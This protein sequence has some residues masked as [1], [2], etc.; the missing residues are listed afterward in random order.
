MLLL[1]Y[2][3]I[4][5]MID[6]KVP[7]NQLEAVVA[8]VLKMVGVE[9]RSLPSRGTAQNMR[10]EMGHVADVVAGALLAKS[11]NVSGASDDTTKRQRSLAAD[12][13]HFKLPDGSFRTL[14]IGLSCKMSS[15]TAAAKVQRFMEKL[16]QV[17]AAVRLSVPLHHGDEA[18]WDRITLLDLVKNNW[19]SDRGAATERNAAKLV[20]ERKAKEARAREGARQLAALRTVGCTCQGDCRALLAPSPLLVNL[21]HRARARAQRLHEVGPQPPRRAHPRPDAAARGRRARA[22]VLPPGA[23][24]RAAPYAR[25]THACVGRCCLSAHAH[26]TPPPAPAKPDSSDD[27]PPPS[28]V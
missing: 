17:Q 26:K 20:E 24:A 11:E 2:S 14:V 13:V 10:R 3:L 21:P 27:E 22:A 5:L 16:A 28:E 25:P 12:L 7:T 18:I 19:C 8:E 6:R 23:A 4:D 1:Q 9:A 15:G